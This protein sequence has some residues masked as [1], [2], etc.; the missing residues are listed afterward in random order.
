MLPEGAVLGEDA[1]AEQRPKV[2][3]SQS[4]AIV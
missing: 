1:A 3:G 4:K 2:R